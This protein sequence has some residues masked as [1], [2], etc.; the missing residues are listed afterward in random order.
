MSAPKPE[1]NE[2]EPDHRL[3]TVPGPWAERNVELRSQPISYDS[4]AGLA[5]RAEI[6]R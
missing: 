1:A 6:Q 4:Y 5:L 2:L 3:G